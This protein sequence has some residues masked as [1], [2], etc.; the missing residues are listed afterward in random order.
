MSCINVY[1][2]GPSDESREWNE[3]ATIALTLEKADFCDGGYHVDED[4]FVRN[5]NKATA[6]SSP[7]R[8]KANNWD[9]QSLKQPGSSQ[10]RAISLADSEDSED[11][12][13]HGDD[14]EVTPVPDAS[15]SRLA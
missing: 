1:A 7:K 12:L 14:I 11:D 2:V 10:Q 4:E 3:I 6:G 5:P 9:T 13:A 15:L 8:K